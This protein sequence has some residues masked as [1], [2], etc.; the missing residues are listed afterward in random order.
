MGASGKVREPNQGGW[1]VGGGTAAVSV[2]ESFGV[3]TLGEKRCSWRRNGVFLK[4]R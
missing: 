3:N 4:L 1:R 2:G